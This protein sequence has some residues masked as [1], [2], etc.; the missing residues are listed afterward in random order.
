MGTFFPKGATKDNVIS[1]IRF[2]LRKSLIESTVVG[3][4]LWGLVELLSDNPNAG[5]KLIICYKLVN[6]KG[7]WGYKPMDETMGP[8]FYD[9]P[10]TFLSNASEPLNEYSK[11]W[12]AEVRKHYIEKCD[13][14]SRHGERME[15]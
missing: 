10:M 5:K 6:S 1:E 3:N 2:D 11:K 15:L 7:G 13:K 12:R 8:N 4:I 14:M 9:C